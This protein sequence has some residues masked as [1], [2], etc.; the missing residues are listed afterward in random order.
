MGKRFGMVLVALSLMGVLCAEGD[1]GGGFGAGVTTPFP[2]SSSDWGIQLGGY[3]HVMWFGFS[4]TGE[5]RMEENDV[6]EFSVFPSLGPSLKLGPVRL[7]IEAGPRFRVVRDGDG[8]FWRYD[9]DGFLTEAEKVIEYFS[10]SPVAYRASA[11]WQTGP[12][13]FGVTYQVDTLFRFKHWY[14]VK[15]LL[16]VDWNTGRYGFLIKYLW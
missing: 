15:D 1:V 5:A 14:E 12:V 10:Y 7:G 2:V 16:D 6:S 9:N 8:N 11:E 4:L 3:A 13:A